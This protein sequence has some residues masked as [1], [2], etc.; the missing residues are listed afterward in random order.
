[1]SKPAGKCIFCGQGNLSKEHLFPN[2]LRNVFPRS[3]LSTHTQG[4][5]TWPEGK[6][7]IKT[8]KG[9]GHSGT[10]KLRVV[11]KK[12]NNGWM[13][14]LEST[15]QPLLSS[16][17][18]GNSVTLDTD[19]QS[20]LSLWVAKTV[21]VAENLNPERVSFDNKSVISS[22]RGNCLKIGMCF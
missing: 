1:V 5:V 13:S 6:K 17:I 7:H 3:A 2:W 22:T 8:K 12:C 19:A 10:K 20:L 11:C 15:S 16:L 9:Q 14:K 4:R 18:D 21:C